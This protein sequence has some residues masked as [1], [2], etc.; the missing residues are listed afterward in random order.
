VH[1]TANRSK[2]NRGLSQAERDTKRSTQKM[3]SYFNNVQNKLNGIGNKLTSIGKQ[4]S[5]SGGLGLAAVVAG[6][7][8][9]IKPAAN[10]QEELLNISTLFSDTQADIGSFKDEI[11]NLSR[12]IPQNT[13]TLTNALYNIKSAGVEA[14]EMFRFLKVSAMSAVAGVTDTDTVVNTLTKTLRGFGMESSEVLQVANKMFRTV[15]KGQVTFGQIA[16][17]LPTVTAAASNAGVSIDEMLGAFATGSKVLKDSAQ[18]A[19]GLAGMLR[20]IGKASDEQK[21]KAKELG[22]EF[23]QQALETKG[24]VEFLGD[25]RESLEGTNVSF[26]EFFR[27]EQ[28]Y[29]LAVALLGDSFDTLK[30]NIDDVSN[31]QDAI[32]RA[33]E[34]QMRGFNNQARLAWNNIVALVKAIGTE[35][36]PEYTN[37][38]KRVRAVASV[39]N[40]NFNNAASDTRER[41][42]SVISTVAK[43]AAGFFG[44]ITVAGLL[45]LGFGLILKAVAL[46]MGAIS[47]LT[48]PIFLLMLGILALA[49]AWKENW[50][51]IR[52][53]IT[54]VSET[55]QE[56]IGSII[57]W[58]TKLWDKI[59]KGDWSGA[60]QQITDGLSNVWKDIKVFFARTPEEAEI[61]NK[62][63]E[64]R[65][66]L[67]ESSFTGAASMLS[68]EK[69]KPGIIYRIQDSWNELADWE[70]WGNI[71]T[72]VK[73]K[74]K[75]TWNF[76][77][78]KYNET[79]GNADWWGNIWTNIVE[80][81]DVT[82][83][84]VENS[85]K[86]LKEK[87]FWGN[88]WDWIKDN[89]E[90]TWD[91]LK[92]E[93]NET[94]GSKDWWG[95]IGD[96]IAEKSEISWN[97][98]TDNWDDVKKWDMWSD[99]GKWI[100]EKSRVSWNKIL[101]LFDGNLS[102][103]ISNA[104]GI[105]KTSGLEETV[106][107]LQKYGEKLGFSAEQLAALAK[108]ESDYK[109][110]ESDKSTAV[111]PLQI[112]ETAIDDLEKSGVTLENSL[113]TLEGRVE[114]AVKYLAL[115]RDKYNLT[116]E[117]LIGSYFAGIGRI[118]N[119]GITDEVVEG[120]I[121]S[122]EYVDRYNNALDKI[123]NQESTLGGTIETVVNATINWTMTFAEGISENIKTGLQTGNWSGLIENIRNATQIY[124]GIAF[125]SQTIS[126]FAASI[127]KKLATQPG[128][129][130]MAG[131]TTLAAATLGLKLAEEIAG[132]EA[133][134]DDIL[135]ALGGATL[136]FVLG[137]PW[138][139]GLGMT[140]AVEFE[141]FSK[142]V[143]K[144]YDALKPI[145]ELLGTETNF[146]YFNEALKNNKVEEGVLKEPDNNNSTSGAGGGGGSAYA[147]GG[148]IAGKGSGKSDSILARLSDGEYVINAQATSKFLP[149][150]QAINSGSL[151]GYA[152]GG[153]VGYEYGGYIES[154]KK[155]LSSASGQLGQTA[156]S[157]FKIISNLLE[158]L[159]QNLADRL[160]EKYPEL[161]E[162]ID[163]FVND[164]QVT[165]DELKGAFEDGGSG[166]GGGG[167]GTGTSFWKENIM[168]SQNINEFVNQLGNNL[169]Q[170]NKH[171]GQ[172]ISNF[173]F[174]TDD[175]GNVMVDFE[176]T[177][178]G[179]ISMFIGVIADALTTLATDANVGTSRGESDFPDLKQL[180]KDYKNFDKNKREL[181]QIRDDI[182][183]L[184]LVGGYQSAPMIQALKQRASQLK[185]TLKTNLQTIKEALGTTVSDV[186]QGLSSAF[187]ADTYSDFVSQFSVN[188]EQTT[189]QG[190][191]RAFMSSDIIRPLLT[192]LSD[193][194]TT[195]VIDGTLSAKERKTITDLYKN[196]T[197]KSS[198]F[199]E[200]L[201]DLGISTEDVSEKMSS[202]STSMKNVPEFFKATLARFRA[203]ET[204]ISSK[205]NARDWISEKI[206]LKESNFP[207]AHVG[208]MVAKTGLI[209]VKAGEIIKTPEQQAGSG[210]IIYIENVYGYD[211]F[212]GKVNTARDETR[213]QRNNRINNNPVN[214]SQPFNS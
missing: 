68:D 156:S 79:L 104:F 33:F 34:K 14:D 4:M 88:L 30:E 17:S 72:W 77:K 198:D 194:I 197:D 99:I 141:V 6:M 73:D 93:W 9:L 206:R 130:A 179:M 87:E 147:S 97:W 89:T 40:D 100:S 185:D 95:N 101:G 209:N 178:S 187:S 109:D 175:L 35:L 85:W 182:A 193:A 96:W 58:V 3:S 122:K 128:F 44:L 113:D 39:L 140:I 27:R 98:I 111:G 8:G 83:D 55:I 75:V 92:K 20:S 66:D 7:T 135:N 10:L 57:D 94:L 119:E 116:G 133:I 24:L 13:K 71:W 53:T 192:Q 196:I 149:L 154:A 81:A 188:L 16:E 132:G 170:V 211:D 199:Y 80:A 184:T 201:K 29:R 76:V 84:F 208:A 139:A 70:G 174:S 167:T 31:S 114:A 126:A 143:N 205:S 131:T 164:V 86:E 65:K 124:L 25:M 186:A 105:E 165:L 150:L 52:D 118:Q 117:E 50:F 54:D 45:S 146:N 74:T 127:G 115:L 107:L 15:E 181:N 22:F 195:A 169:K 82:W 32:M 11:L 37:L 155:M 19:V 158:T 153:L 151:P 41:I 163:G 213:T 112:T 189:R 160:R 12:V 5:M 144:I 59:A 173:K 49:T 162:S 123:G 212:K 63:V 110:V 18:T 38:A 48:S 204:S 176:A 108:I 191:I 106:G 172:F 43:L 47:I 2:L 171:L 91:W 21:E 166:D 190:L 203:A 136:G 69:V 157:F 214:A 62:A 125:A 1:V 46:V 60:W 56:K 210:E 102:D 183:R 36:L 26:R 61:I 202:L 148:K 51:G 67:N 137:G 180:Y 42:A 207:S 90:I 120:Q 23:S 177:L 152:S 103:R 64:V 200:A 129:A 121:S 161:A 134:M 168:N 28:G 159:L 142:S 78:T 138:G 145:R